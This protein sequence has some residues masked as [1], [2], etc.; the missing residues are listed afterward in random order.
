M[1]REHRNANAAVA[2][3]T[4]RDRWIAMDGY[5]VVD[6]IWIVEQSERTFSPA[7]DLAVDLE[8]AC[9]GDG[10]PCHTAFCKKLAGSRRDRQNA[11]RDTGDIDDKQDLSVEIDL[12]MRI[13]GLQL[14][15]SL[16]DAQRIEL[17]EGQ[18]AG[19]P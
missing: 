3:G 7:F 17:L 9:R 10:A 14:W 4:D 18:D 2:G 5:A 12:N 6:V 1:R 8:P 16:R 11:Q 13:A 15:W 19:P